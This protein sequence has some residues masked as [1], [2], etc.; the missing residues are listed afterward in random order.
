MAEEAVDQQAG[1]TSPGHVLEYAALRAVCVFVG[2]LPLRLAL[3]FG[4]GLGWVA[5]SV[6]RIR[7]SVVLTNLT[8]AFPDLKDR[9]RRRIACRS[10]SSIGRFA[11]EF[12]RQGRVNRQYFRKYI[13]VEKPELVKRISE[14]DGVVG[15]GFHF[16]NWELLG[17]VQ[18]YLGI[19]VSF[20]V[21]EQRNRLVDEY[22][23]SL[24]ASHGIR[25]IRRDGAMRGII[26]T[27]RS[28]GVVCWLS[29][30]D[31]GRSG[32]LVDFFGYPA[33]TPRGAAAFA[34]KLGKPIACMYLVR[35]RGPYHRVI[36]SPLFQPRKDL[37]R[38][39]AETELTQRY[40]AHLQS[41]IERHPEQYWWPHRRWKTTGLYEDG[42]ER[43][44]TDER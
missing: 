36:A 22:I 34:C 11:V 15:L 43:K 10:Y 24:R 2:L 28:G 26:S 18:A 32:V 25:L 23:N 17:V 30:Q 41:V 7:R 19:D 39:E 44:A 9:K 20:L 16:G 40:T 3:L 29:D 1:R 27:I 12:A 37:E 42:S 21:G 14:A 4:A 38:E 8:L 6:L 33:S 5:W 13:S 35:I 31:S